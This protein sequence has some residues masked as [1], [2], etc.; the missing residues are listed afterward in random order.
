[1]S[2]KVERIDL[3]DAGIRELL[4]DSGVMAVVDNAV[5]CVV[6]RAGNDLY[7]G[8]T[9]RGKTRAQGMV[10]AKNRHGRNHNNKYNTLITSL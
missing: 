1:M 7:A 10:Y 2:L 3:D 5:Q 6:R 9:R 4:N 8:D